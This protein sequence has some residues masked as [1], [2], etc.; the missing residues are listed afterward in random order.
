ME[1]YTLELYTRPT[2]SDCQDAKAYLEKHQIPYEGIDLSVHP[3]K[4]A[5][6]QKVSGARVVPAFVFRPVSMLWKWKKPSVYIGFERNMEAIKQ[7]L[8]Q[9]KQTP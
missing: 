2:C 8:E 1:N 3:E 5:D 9:V 6:L 4:E 7:K